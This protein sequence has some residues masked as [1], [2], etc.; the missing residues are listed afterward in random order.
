MP[1]GIVS[2]SEFD[3][4]LKNS[5]PRTIEPK[6]EIT[7]EI[8]DVNK[9][10]GTGNLEV[11]NSLRQIIGETSKIDGR[12][13]ALDL[14]NQ[15]GISPS[16][17]SAYANGAT[18]TASF[19]STPNKNHIEDS[20][21]RVSNRARFKLMSALK[22]MTADKLAGAKAKDL[23]GIAKDMSA[24]IRNMEPEKSQ[25]P[26]DEKK[27]PTFVFYAPQFKDEKS[28]DIIHVKE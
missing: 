1:L 9:G 14:A 6:D 8:I 19:D 22:H 18:S 10:R 4:E 3:Y 5:S 16:S 23:A 21:L 13:E 20:K 15:F 12:Q 26:N 17:V 7:A 24:V 25:N 11:P 28:Y 2:D 27:G